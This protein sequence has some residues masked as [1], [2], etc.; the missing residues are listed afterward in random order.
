MSTPEPITPETRAK[1]TSSIKDD[2][3]SIPEA[4]ATY[5]VAEPTVRRWLRATTDNAHTSTSELQ[6]LRR[7]N[8]VLKEAIGNIV[9]QTELQKKNFTRP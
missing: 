9:L 1:A 3:V 6:R 7:E 5:G 2:G 8:S 4:A